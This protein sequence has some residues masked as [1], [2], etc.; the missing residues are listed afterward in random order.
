MTARSTRPAREP[1]R[2]PSRELAAALVLSTSTLLAVAAASPA[3]GA[4]DTKSVPPTGGKGGDRAGQPAKDH[5]FCCH[6]GPHGTLEGRMI[7][8]DAP[9]PL[10]PLDSAWNWETLRWWGPN[11]NRINMVFVGDGYQADDL[12]LYRTQVEGAWNFLAAKQPYASY[13]RYFNVHRVDVISVDQGV[14][15]D[16]T[17][18]IAR[19]TALDMAFWGGGVERL[20]SVDLAKAQ[21]AAG[22]APAW[23]QVLA[24][25]NSSK[26][27]GAGW[28]NADVGTFSGGNSASFPL[29]EH[30]LGHSFGDLA[31]EYDYDADPPHYSGPE[32]VERN[33]SIRDQR[34]MIADNAK[35][36]DWLGVSLPGIGVHGCFEGAFYHETGAYRPSNDSLMRNLGLPYNGPSIEQMIVKIHLDTAMADQLTHPEGTSVRAGG[37]VGATLVE[38]TSHSLQKVWKLGGVVI[39][40]ANSAFLETGALDIP[41]VGTSL[42]LEVTDPNPLVRNIF[43]KLL[44]MREVYSWTLL[45]ADGLACANAI[46]VQPSNPASS[47]FDTRIDTTPSDDTPCAAGDQWAVWR[48][49]IATCDGMMTVTACPSVFASGRVTLAMAGEC[50]PFEVCST[51]NATGCSSTFAS[52]IRFGVTA[53]EDYFIRISALGGEDVAG[54]LS[55]SCT[56][57][58]TTGSCFIARSNPGCSDSSCCAVTCTA[59]PFCCDSQWDVLCVQRAEAT[60]RSG[61]NCDEARLLWI[62]EPSSYSFVTGGSVLASTPTSCGLNDYY[63]VWR[64][65]VAP[66]SGM[67][68]VEICTEFATSQPTL[69]LYE[70][71]TAPLDALACSASPSTG[72]TLGPSVRIDHAVLAGRSYLIR[73]GGKGGL[74]IA[75]TLEIENSAVCGSGGPCLEQ[76]F[77][78]GCDDPEC[79]VAVCNLDPYC[80]TNSW[81]SYC[82]QSAASS[83]ANAP[84]DINNDGAVNAAD[85]S[86]LLGAWGASGGAADLNGDGT[87]GAADLALLL[88]GWTG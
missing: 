67:L 80:C 7:E 66:A 52:S 57:T 49:I 4:G 21:Q 42:T 35:W 55:V 10:P 48:R 22:C 76:H 58:C 33:V 30:E 26:Y 9:I 23:D 36:V 25:A 63:P 84:G 87:V 37:A 69:A 6:P 39:P 28:R 51:D 70:D 53:G 77:E 29:A 1:S 73:I 17:Q 79:C 18:G 65:Y 43:F 12:A 64:R 16:P 85:L 54:T 68:R 31:D 32:F 44:V 83:C 14:D 82:V 46:T 20:L 11:E 60:C 74:P 56:T 41:P 2:T 75:G 62:E 3:L 5:L 27:G 61:L 38:P 59:D 47:S 34:T 71:C 24:V 72:C 13:H 50:G 88:G 8:V 40:G 15:N 81:D 78:P 86:L 45:P 19:N